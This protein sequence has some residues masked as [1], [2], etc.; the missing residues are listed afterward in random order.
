MLSIEWFCLWSSTDIALL[1]SSKLKR[2]EHPLNSAGNFTMHRSTTKYTQQNGVVRFSLVL[3]CNCNS[4]TAV[5]CCR[6]TKQDYMTAIKKLSTVK[7]VLTLTRLADADG[8]ILWPLLFR[9]QFELVESRTGRVV[10]PQLIMQIPQ[11]V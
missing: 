10:S 1:T 5:I 11:Q 2:D 4:Y 7:A 8:V 6:S 3:H 9:H